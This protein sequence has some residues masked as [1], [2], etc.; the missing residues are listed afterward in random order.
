MKDY[1]QLYYDEL[2][3][4]KELIQKCKELEEELEL[5][6]KYSKKGAIIEQIMKDLMKYMKERVKEDGE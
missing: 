6:K 4:N 1:E 3:K 2:Y 5:L